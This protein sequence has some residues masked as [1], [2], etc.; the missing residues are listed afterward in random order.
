MLLNRDID[1]LTK[2]PILVYHNLD[3]IIDSMKQ[4]DI[5]YRIFTIDE[6]RFEQQMKYLYQQGYQS[7]HLSNLVETVKRS[8]RF[9]D[10][11]IVI[12]F[13][14][15]HISNYTLAYPILQKHGF[16]A[17]F[18]VVC[19]WIGLSPYLSWEQISEISDNGI[20][21]GSHTLTHPNLT[22][23]DSA[24]IR[25]ELYNSK[26][27]LEDKLRRPVRFLSTPGGVYNRLI[28]QIAE[29]VGYEGICAP[30][31]SAR[32]TANNLLL[33][34]RLGIKGYLPVSDYVSL[35]EM[36]GKTAFLRRIEIVFK[37]LMKRYLGVERYR[38]IRNKWLGLKLGP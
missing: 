31:R 29:E 18:F 8:T 38:W 11:S 19:N 25:V 1:L 16:K 3:R 17:T 10:K 33:I 12:T 37:P 35:L 4:K 32:I 26:C 36:R 2:F 13:D 7:I 15:G 9:E 21:I 34:P 14:D 30:G 22:E 27:I 20:E 24:R 6:A 5:V 23:L 28:G